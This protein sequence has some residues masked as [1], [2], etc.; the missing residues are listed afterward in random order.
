VAWLG[1]WAK[2]RP[3]TISNTNIDSDLTHFPLLLKLSSSAGTGSD[4]VTDVFDSLG[5]NSKKIAVTKSD[6]TTQLY[7]EIERWDNTNEVAELWVSKS[8]WEIDADASTTIY[9]YYDNS[10]DDNTTYVGD[11]TSE[12]V[13]TNVWDSNFKGVWHLASTSATRGP[14]FTNINSV[15]FNAA[16]IGLGADQ[17]S[18]NTNKYLYTTTPT[19]TKAEIHAQYTIEAWSYFYAKDKQQQ[20]LGTSSTT[21]SKWG[22]GKFLVSGGNKFQNQPYGPGMADPGLLSS[23][24]ISTG[25]WY[26][27]AAIFNGSTQYIYVNGSS[28]NSVSYT[29]SDQSG[30]YNGT[31]CGTER[32][33]AVGPGET[34]ESIIDEARISNI[35]RSDAWM[36]ATYYS[37]ADGLVDWGNSEAPDLK[38][39]LTLV[40]SIIK[41]LGITKADAFSLIESS[42]KQAVFGKSPLESVSLSD[43]LS[44]ASTFAK[45]K[46][47]PLSLADTITRL[48]GIKKS[49]SE[50][51]T[52]V[53]SLS[54]SYGMQKT[55][56]IGLIDLV[57]KQAAFA[58]TKTDPVSLS[59]VLTKQSTFSRALTNSLA[60]AESFTKRAGF[61]ITL[62]END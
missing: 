2:R 29:Y 45:T 27:V 56:A 21:S 44:K 5:A 54:L 60:V 40:D 10:Q 35:A 41:G 59:D 57:L 14:N 1:T 50:I 49:V 26:H 22:K 7:V 23:T 39:S 15:A 48:F 58:K 46:T 37:G 31:W 9:F 43:V 25:T 3:I 61:N 19:L 62:K 16:K 36:K 28:E 52:L 6:G 38:E 55:D 20:Q 47:D 33:S 18:G 42:S 32:D 51:T 8:D 11:I 13:I 30:T 53:D 24:T 4:D 12:S 34:A 17:G